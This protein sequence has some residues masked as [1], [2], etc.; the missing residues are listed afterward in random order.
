MN[1]LDI[2]NYPEF[3]R[4]CDVSKN[5]SDDSWFYDNVNEEIMFSQHRS[6]VYFIVVDNEIVKTGLHGNRYR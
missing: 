3:E 6:W 4:V 1:L 5:S 2:R